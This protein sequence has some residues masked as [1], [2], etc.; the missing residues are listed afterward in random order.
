[1]EQFKVLSP[2]MLTGNFQIYMTVSGA[3]GKDKKIQVGILLHALGEEA[4]EI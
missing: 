1:M 3:D 4:L 2:L